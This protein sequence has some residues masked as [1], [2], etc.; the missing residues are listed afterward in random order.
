M[1]VRFLSKGLHCAW[2]KIVIQSRFYVLHAQLFLGLLLAL[3][4][5]MVKQATFIG[6]I[7]PVHY[8][9]CE[10]NSTLVR[11]FSVW[12]IVRRTSD[13][14][15]GSRLSQY[16]KDGN[17]SSVAAVY[18]CPAMSRSS[19]DVLVRKHVTRLINTIRC[20]VTKATLGLL[21]VRGTKHIHSSPRTQP[22]R[23]NQLFNLWVPPL[24]LPIPPHRLS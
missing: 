6:V 1:E 9:I 20:V 14:G 18:L 22:L 10:D 21:P 4:F 15:G 12:L 16:L 5:T 8:N 19:L 24:C 13:M 17:R 2:T 11:I 3:L 7:A 23:D